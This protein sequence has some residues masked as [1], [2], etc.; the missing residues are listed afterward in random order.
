L[1]AEY[2]D[3]VWASSLGKLR[4]EAAVSEKRNS[5]EVWRAAECGEKLAKGSLNEYLKYDTTVSPMTQRFDYLT[6][7]VNSNGHY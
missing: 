4:Q 2:L 6:N 7:R 3:K 5:E 1:V